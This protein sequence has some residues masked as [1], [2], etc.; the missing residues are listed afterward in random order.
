MFRSYYE[1]LIPLAPINA[2]EVD[3]LFGNFEYLDLFV[4]TKCLVSLFWFYKEY[5]YSYDYSKNGRVILEALSKICLGCRKI[6][7]SFFVSNVLR[8]IISSVASTNI[9]FLFG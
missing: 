2:K 6:G 5:G 4:H 9:K 8:T 1:P 7:A 3:D